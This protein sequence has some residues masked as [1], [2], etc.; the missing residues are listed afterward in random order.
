[1][2]NPY[3]E[4]VRRYGPEKVLSAMEHVA[5][6]HQQNADMSDIQTWADEVVGILSGKVRPGRRFNPR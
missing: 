2:K 3:F 1:M 6:Q 5:A 4:Y